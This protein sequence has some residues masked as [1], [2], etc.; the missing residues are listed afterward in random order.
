MLAPIPWSTST[1]RPG[2]AAKFAVRAPVRK[3]ASDALDAFVLLARYAVAG[4]A[5]DRI[6]P[7]DRERIEKAAQPCPASVCI[8][9]EKRDDFSIGV[10]KPV[11]AR[12]RHPAGVLGDSQAPCKRKALNH[13]RCPLVRARID[14]YH[15]GRLGLHPFEMLQARPNELA[16]A[17]T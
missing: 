11:V 17:R 14:H 7:V 12:G 16:G 9:I 6:N 13:L 1:R 10:E 3:E 15:L 8:V 2:S 5:G 4:S